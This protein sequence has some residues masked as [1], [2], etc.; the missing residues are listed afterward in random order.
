MPI[1][2]EP[3]TNTGKGLPNV[4]ASSQIPADGCPE[5]GWDKI[6]NFVVALMIFNPE[7]Q[8]DDE[9]LVTYSGLSDW[10]GEEWFECH[11]CGRRWKSSVR[12]EV[13]P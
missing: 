9:V 8:G 6:D 1:G 11:P 5:H 2:A 4:S 12:K 10:T 7:P 3:T 13:Y